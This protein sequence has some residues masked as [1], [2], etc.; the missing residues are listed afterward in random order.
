MRSGT[1]L[2]SSAHTLSGRRSPRAPP[3]SA[4]RDAGGNR[5]ESARP[6]GTPR[7]AGNIVVEAVR[8]DAD[9][10]KLGIQAPE[11]VPVH[12]EEVQQQVNTGVQ[13]GGQASTLK[14]ALGL[15]G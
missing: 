6:P 9:Q 10:I 2:D 13:P 11:S 4:G 3:G 5:Q 1:A 12:R 14:A 8:V 15:Q 7:L